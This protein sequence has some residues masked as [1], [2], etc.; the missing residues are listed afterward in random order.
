MKK[1]CIFLLLDSI[2]YDVL[3][4]NET[5]KTARN[6]FPNIY[7]LAKK[8]NFQKCVSNSNCTQFVLPSLFS[9]TLPLDDGGYDYGIKNK[10]ISFMEILKKEGYSTII[11]SNCNQMGADN[12]YDRGVDENINSF[13]YRLILEQK[14]NR[15]ILSKY[16]KNKENTN[17]KI[18]LIESY[19]KL[20]NE[21]KTKIINADT[22]IWSRDLRK[23]NTNIKNNIDL[24]IDLINKKPEIILK[25]NT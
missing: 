16:R 6:L 1:N 20:L 18:E 8:Y 19:K 5:T 10:K 11:F 25:K 22:L 9:F 21:I 24:E 15:V 23:I 17:S 3:N 14:L 4:S 2:T 7:H 12:G 13:D